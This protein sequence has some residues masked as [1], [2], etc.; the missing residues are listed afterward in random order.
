MDS[1]T[2][3]IMITNP[4]TLGMFKRDIKICD[5][6]HERGGYV[7][8]DGANMN[9]ILGIARPGDL[10]ID[11]IIITKPSPP[12]WRRWAGCGCGG[13]ECRL[14]TLLAHPLVKRMTMALAISTMTAQKRRSY[15]PFTATLG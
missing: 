9:A 12:S 2:A 3:G 11:V 10:G 15:L 1:D 6:V 7:Y 8:G 13:C 5:V 14:R 4:N